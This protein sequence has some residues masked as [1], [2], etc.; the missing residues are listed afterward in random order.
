MY[1]YSIYHS[2]LILLRKPFVLIS[3]ASWALFCQEGS[4]E[5]V[6]KFVFLHPFFTIFV[7]LHVNFVIMWRFISITCLLIY[8]FATWRVKS[9]T[10]LACILLFCSVGIEK[11]TERNR[12]SWKLEIHLCVDLVK[13]LNERAQTMGTIFSFPPQNSTPNRA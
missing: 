12:E 13:Y 3:S 1:N 7:S 2:L 10:S 5:E 11:A 4:I 9:M 6:R 8:S